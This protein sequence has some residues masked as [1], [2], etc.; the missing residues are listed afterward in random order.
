MKNMNT[1]KRILGLLGVGFVQGI[2]M[3]ATIAL[4]IYVAT[5][6]QEEKAYNESDVKKY[7]ETGNIRFSAPAVNPSRGNEITITFTVKNPDEK[8]FQ[9]LYWDI[10][11]FD[12]E[13]NFLFGEN[14]GFASYLSPKIEDNVSLEVIM[15]NTVSYEDIHSVS[16]EVWAVDY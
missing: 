14:M 4:V 7:Y 13:G 5:E 11:L 15:P 10:E 8:Y 6:M 1:L 12:E 16:V 2:A 9:G 3:G